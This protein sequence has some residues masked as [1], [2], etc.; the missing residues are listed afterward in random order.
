MSDCIFGDLHSTPLPNNAFLISTVAETEKLSMNA[1]RRS[2]VGGVQFWRVDVD[3]SDVEATQE[4][5]LKGELLRA[6]STGP[7]SS[8]LPVSPVQQ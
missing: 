3:S 6:R 7:V 2:T 8:D 1:Q 5:M 4:P